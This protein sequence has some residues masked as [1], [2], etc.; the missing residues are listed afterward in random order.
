MLAVEQVLRSGDALAETS[1]E[2]LVL[3]ARLYMLGN[4]CA[5]HIGDW[6][7]VDGSDQLELLS[8]LGAETDCHGF[9]G[10]HQLILPPFG[11]LLQV[12]W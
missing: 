2:G 1:L 5:D 3:A 9:P 8:L 12:S 6:L 10:T 7:I 4:C 11:M